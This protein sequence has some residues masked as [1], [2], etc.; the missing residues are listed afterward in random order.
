MSDLQNLSTKP[1]IAELEA[2]LKDA[3]PM[4]GQNGPLRDRANDLLRGIPEGAAKS[5]VDSLPAGLSRNHILPT[6]DTCKFV[7]VSKAHWR[8]LGVER[9]T[10]AAIMIGS[11][12]K[13][14]R[15][16]DLIDW[17]E[18]RSQAAPV[19]EPRRDPRHVLT[20]EPVS[21]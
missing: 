13:G 6:E 18:S 17:L 15:I 4:L 1:R 8:R 5:I 2:F 10:P 3:L 12:R 19:D 9:Q 16:G 20:S 14:W 7:G 21:P 11:R